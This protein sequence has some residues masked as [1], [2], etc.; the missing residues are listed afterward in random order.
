MR[1]RHLAYDVA[2]DEHKLARI[3]QVFDAAIPTTPR[4]DRAKFVFIIGLPRSGTTLLERVLSNLPGVATN[5]E[6]DN[7]LLGT[8]NCCRVR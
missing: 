6:T 8:S 5:G 1:R 4:K 7:F 2:T 3:A